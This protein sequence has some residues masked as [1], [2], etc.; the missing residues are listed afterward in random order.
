MD[1]QARMYIFY[2]GNG[3][4]SGTNPKQLQKIL[5][6]FFLLVFLPIVWLLHPWRL[7]ASCSLFYFYFFWFLGGQILNSKPKNEIS[8]IL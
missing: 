4:K 1:V 6:F 3:R 2:I 5:R 7:R 8:G